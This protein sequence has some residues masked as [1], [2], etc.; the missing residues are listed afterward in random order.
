[1][2][3]NSKAA[4]EQAASRVERAQAASRDAEKARA[5]Y[6][7]EGRALRE[8]TARLKSLRLAKEAVDAAADAE[9]K[10]VPRESEKKPVPRENEKKPVPREKKPTS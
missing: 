10:P 5:Q 4:R 9:K 1:M 6:E 2:V 8:K 7:A 3:D